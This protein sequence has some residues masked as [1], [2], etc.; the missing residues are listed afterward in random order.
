MRLLDLITLPTSAGIYTFGPCSIANAW[1]GTMPRKWG[2]W[3]FN[4][5]TGAALD[6]TAGNFVAQYTPVKYQNV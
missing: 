5:G 3:L 2:V 1:G 4:N 6:A